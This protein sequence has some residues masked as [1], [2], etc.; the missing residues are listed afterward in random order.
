MA[1]RCTAPLEV[2]A[3]HTRGNRLSSEEAIWMM[4][5]GAPS[6][7][8]PKFSRHSLDCLSCIMPQQSRKAR[9]SR[10]HR[11]EADR[12]MQAADCFGKSAVRRVAL[13]DFTSILGQN[14]DT[15]A[16]LLGAMREF[17][18]DLDAPVGRGRREVAALDRENGLAR[19][20]DASDRLAPFRHERSGTEIL[21][22]PNAEVRRSRAVTTCARIR[23]G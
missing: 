17:M 4:F 20:R 23:A 10:V 8:R 22:V 11:R 3:D 1:A 6:L 15:R 18:T 7:A 12:T 9:C 14:R 16:A 13:E 19:G 5:T 21:A 2:A